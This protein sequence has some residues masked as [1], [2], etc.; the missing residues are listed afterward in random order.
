MQQRT[1]TIKTPEP[2]Y[3]LFSATRAGL[4]E[5]V[6]VNDALL[7]FPHNKVFGWHLCVTLDAK[8]LIENGM[9][10]SVES[11]LLFEIGDEIEQ[12]VLA[13]RTE[14]NGENALFLARSTWNEQRELLFQVYDPDITHAALQS[15]LNGR[16]WQ[17][18]W[19]YHMERDTEW[20]N[21]AYIFQLFP[22]A[23]GSDA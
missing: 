18:E 10:S 9:P 3:T 23:N 19:D 15:L 6:V 2:H 7:S 13:G 17:R 4:P 16:N 11:A 21:A 14:T 5:I 8:E 1:V 20:S 12:V 22:Q